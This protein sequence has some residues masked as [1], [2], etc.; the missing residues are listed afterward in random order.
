[1]WHTTV[2]CN[3]LLIFDLKQRWSTFSKFQNF[4]MADKGHVWLGTQLCPAKILATY[5]I[6]AL[7][8][9]VAKV[10]VANENLPTYL[11]ILFRVLAKILANR[12][13]RNP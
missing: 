1:M 13:P 12:G 6:L 2:H 4:Q 8:W 3:L 11:Y 9:L 5:D 10:L 7:V